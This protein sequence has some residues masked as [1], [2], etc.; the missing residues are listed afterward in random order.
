M[1]LKLDDI[2]INSIIGNGSFIKGNFVVNGFVRIDGDIDG[3][4]ETDGNVILGEH[5]RIRGNIT[6]KS[7]IVGGVIL[8][9]ISVKDSVKL[10]SSSAVIGDILCR[11]IQIDDDVV[12]HG[13]CISLKDD[14]EFEAVSEKYLQEKAIKEKVKV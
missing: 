5:A 7:L 4:L 3:N 14:K 13:H 6:A 11:K 9:N 8:G 1:A 2:S 10:L 12:F